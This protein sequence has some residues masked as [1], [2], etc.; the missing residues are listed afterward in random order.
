MGSAGL[1]IKIRTREG[2]LFTKHNQYS[3]PGANLVPVTATV[4]LH[5]SQGKISVL[6]SLVMVNDIYSSFF[7]G[8]KLNRCLLQMVWIG[9]VVSDIYW[10]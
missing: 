10:D 1:V 6:F 3:A 7:I 2:N 9:R 4:T 5:L 8:L